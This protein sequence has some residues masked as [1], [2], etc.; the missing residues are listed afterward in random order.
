MK[1]SS[2]KENVTKTNKV[3]QYFKAD[4]KLSEHTNIRITQ[5][6][7]LLTKTMHQVKIET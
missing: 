7:I 2:N 5:M 4:I 6:M 1:K 3:T